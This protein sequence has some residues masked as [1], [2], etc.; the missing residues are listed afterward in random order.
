MAQIGDLT[1]KIGIEGANKAVQDLEKVRRQLE[2]I[3]N[4]ARNT[5]AS[6]ATF[7]TQLRQ[8]SNAANQMGAGFNAGAQGAQRFNYGIQNTTRILKDLNSGNYR[9]GLLDVVQTLGAVK[10]LRDGNFMTDFQK[11]FRR[12]YGGNSRMNFSEAAVAAY[13]QGLLRRQ[14]A[15]Q[16]TS[17]GSA[18]MNSP[19]FQNLGITRVRQNTEGPGAGLLGGGI[20]LPYGV[21]DFASRFG[22][23]LLNRGASGAIGT[24]FFSNSFG[25]G[26]GAAGFG[27]IGFLGGGFGSI[28][29][30]GAISAVIGILT[31]TIGL[32]VTYM[33]TL[34][35]AV[36]Q[37]S[38]A[39]SKFV[40]Q[41]VNQAAQFQS[42]RSQN[43]SA[44]LGSQFGGVYNPT[45]LSAARAQSKLQFDYMR[46]IA[47][48]SI[49]TLPEMAG[50]ANILSTAGIPL[51]R[52]L[53]VTALTGQ[54]TGLRG[55][56]VELVARMF[57]R[58]AF[59][60]FP[61]PE[62]G[63]RFGLVRNNP[64]L[65]RMGMK[66]DKSGQM[67]TGSADAV[68]IVMKFLSKRFGS[69]FLVAAMDFNTKFATL[70]DK[71][72]T[73]LEKIGTPIMNSLIPVFETLGK[74]MD[75]FVSKGVFERLGGSIALFFDNLNTYLQSPDF[76][77]HAA[78]FFAI[79]EEIPNQL[80]VMFN[81]FGKFLTKLIDAADMIAKGGPLNLLKE[82]LLNIFT[83][84]AYGGIKLGKL[85]FDAG[86]LDFMAGQLAAPETISLNYDYYKRMLGG[87][88]YT[89]P[90]GTGLEKEDYAGE[91]I[92]KS[93][94]E[95]A[96][97]T[98]QLLDVAKKTFDIFDMRRQTIGLGPLGRLGVTGAE[99]GSMGLPFT[100]S[101]GISI[102]PI[103]GYN[104]RHPGS[105]SPGPVR[106]T[107]MMEK[108]VKQINRES[109]NAG[110]TGR[111]IRTSR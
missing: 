45:T 46:E 44:I 57:S 30:L 14:A 47:E 69:G 85:A 84:G 26:R 110:R 4:L 70:S 78:F 83:F 31:T 62:V 11:L 53:E 18:I 87:P 37:A 81:F 98:K 38:Q 12:T 15:F 25:L 33:K 56:E 103:T 82:G 5:A 17:F 72:A 79:L 34:S 43:I 107:T 97:N 20:G 60:D 109:S 24:P 104:L 91:N 108:G 92:K 35:T 10:V 3:S 65:Q 28:A 2:L 23:N 16:R 48:K 99:F 95:T 71:F 61:D 100:E 77:N 105:I 93:T 59:G 52:F 94:E 39:M 73:V 55:R 13:E 106:G 89:P 80:T 58:L 6:F 96:K 40:V 1:V 54:A 101:R 75:E 63:A 8:F 50:A 22:T 27:R 102:G 66:F 36:L 68:N 90:K 7:N 74:I 21:A 51:N 42:I 49:Y 41:A 88:G 67:V 86:F 76:K 29:G 19:L 64:E 9:K 32:L 111:G